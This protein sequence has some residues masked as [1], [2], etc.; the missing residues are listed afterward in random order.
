MKKALLT[1]VLALT[2]ISCKKSSV[3]LEIEQYDL[4]KAKLGYLKDLIDTKEN[5]TYKEQRRLIDSLIVEEKTR[6]E[7]ESN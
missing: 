3:E 7:N 5:L 1:L 2:L 6:L 4:R